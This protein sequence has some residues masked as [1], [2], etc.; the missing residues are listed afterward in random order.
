MPDAF[1]WIRSSTAMQCDDATCRYRLEQNGSGC[2]DEKD[3]RFGQK[4]VHGGCVNVKMYLCV[5]V[6]LF[7]FS[8]IGSRR[9]C[10]NR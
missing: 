3:R 8:K 10:V 7:C 2:G 5:C 4:S 9:V 1:G 6:C